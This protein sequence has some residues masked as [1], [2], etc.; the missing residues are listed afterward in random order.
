MSIAEAIGID[1]KR[2]RLHPWISDQVVK[3]GSVTAAFT[4]GHNAAISPP[5]GG[6]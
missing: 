5:R 6:D 1:D 4:K 2:F 3:G